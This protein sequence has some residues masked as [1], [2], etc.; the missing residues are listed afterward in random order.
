MEKIG[1]IGEYDKI[2][3]IIYV[4][5]ILTELG[6]KVLIL[7]ATSKQKSRYVVPTINPTISYLTQFQDIDIAVGLK[8]FE[9]MQRYLSVDEEELNYDYMLID[10]NTSEGIIQNA[11]TAT[12]KVYYVT[13]FDLYT[14]K[15]GIE[16]ISE[17]TEPLKLT[18]IYFSRTYSNEDDEYLEFLALG[19]KIM[20]DE[21]I[22]Y[23]PLE[24]GD[25]T[26]IAENQRIS[27]IKYRNL[28]NDYKEGLISLASDILAKPSKEI[29]SLV[30]KL[31]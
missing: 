27:K 31:E 30:R 15:K 25:A 22:I 10:I 13:S 28:S 23:F 8:N 26:V 3:L 5:K 17:I 16:I 20:W 19:K 12:D 2:D 1:F 9:N 11:L 6:K 24:N 7:D 18:K 29:K 21:N 14:L 4:A